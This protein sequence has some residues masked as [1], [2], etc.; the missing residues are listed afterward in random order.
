MSLCPLCQAKS[1]QCFVLN[2]PKICRDG[3]TLSKKIPDFWLWKLPKIVLTGLV[4]LTAKNRA[5]SQPIFGSY[6]P[7]MKKVC[8]LT[9]IRTSRPSA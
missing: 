3:T 6:N 9:E 8:G 4:I 5:F 1:K 2:T 7:H